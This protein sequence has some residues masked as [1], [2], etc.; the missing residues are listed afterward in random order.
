MELLGIRFCSVNDTATADVDFF[1]KG[2][3]LNNSLETSADFQGGVFPTPD[4]SS[5]LEIWQSSEAMP[6]GVMLQ[7]IV[8]DADALAVHARAQ[9]LSPSG[10]VDAHG[11]R[12]YYLKAPSG[13]SL[14]FQSKL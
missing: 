3:G 11:E 4:A 12:I 5:W 7:L 8:A 10:P 14:S 13:L 1:E 9:G 2:L 6:A